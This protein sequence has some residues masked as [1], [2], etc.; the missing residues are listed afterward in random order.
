MNASFTAKGVESPRLS[1][2]MLLS[3]V[4]GCDRL[5]LYTQADRPASP[6]E[7]AALRDL[8]ARALRHE[9]IQYLVGEA[10]FFGL[11]FTVD[12]RVLIPRPCTE[13]IVERVLQHA[14]SRPGF[15]GTA[16]D[17]VLI[18]D[19]CTGSGC[20]GIALAKHLPHARILCTDLSENALQIARLNATR[21][22][23]NDRIDFRVGNLLEPVLFH[24][25]AGQHGSLSYLVANPPYISDIEWDTAMGQNVRGHEPDMALRGGHDG[26]DL[27]RPLIAQSPKLLRPDGLLIIECAAS[28]A[29][30]VR[31]L[32]LESPDLESIEMVRDDDG[33]LRTLVA[34]K[35]HKTCDKPK[36][37]QN[38]TSD[39]NS[40]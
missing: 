33:L 3:H 11:A 36:S 6:I 8:V 27:I 37:S 24:T 19:V 20:I 29:D 35:C 16:G 1:S 32:A 30:T 23:V 14:R 7:R 9:P 34:A 17:A 13:I 18:A 22:G 38:A 26:L 39:T 12:A 31:T 28:T 15:G 2:E 5:K 10:W 40:G 4:I 21:H 25:A